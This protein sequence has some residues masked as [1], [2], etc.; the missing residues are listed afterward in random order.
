MLLLSSWLPGSPLVPFVGPSDEAIEMSPPMLDESVEVSSGCRK[1]LLSSAVDWLSLLLGP[2]VL[3][4]VDPSPPIVVVVPVPAPAFVVV[5]IVPGVM[6]TENDGRAAAAGGG[7]IKLV[8]GV[9]TLVDGGWDSRAT[10]SV[11]CDRAILP[12]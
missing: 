11:L 12:P 2:P 1:L 3:A 4:R 8:L 5:V 6:E 10:R 7:A 9:G